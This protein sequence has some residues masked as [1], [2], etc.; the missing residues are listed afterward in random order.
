MRVIDLMTILPRSAG[1]PQRARISA[2]AKHAAAT[3]VIDD[4]PV[5]QVRQVLG[6]MIDTHRDHI[7][8][9]GELNSTTLAEDACHVFNLYAGD[10]CPENLFELASATTLA[11][12][13][14]N[15]RA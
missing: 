13:A 12:E 6:W 3:V 10:A 14:E 8:S 4:M 2:P 9:G 11:Y 15:D 5:S 1:K 7:D